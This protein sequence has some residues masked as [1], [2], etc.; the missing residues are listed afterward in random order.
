MPVQTVVRYLKPELRDA[1]T[2]PDIGDRESR[3]ANT[4]KRPV[5]IHDARPRLASGDIALDEHGFALEQHVSAVGDFHDK[6]EVERTYYPEMHALLRRLT[7]AS[8]VY[9]TQ[10][11]VRTEDT[12]NFN[13]AY[14]RFV[15]CD[16]SITN[17]REAA[18]NLLTQ[19]GEDPD[20]FSHFAWYNTWQPVE[21]EVFQNPLAVID[22][23]SLESGDVVDYYYT[24][25]G[26]TSISSMPVENDAH[27]FFYFSRMQT[28]EV[29]VIKQLDTRAELATCCP[30]TSFVD[31]DVPDDMPGRRSI[32][33]RLLC[34]FD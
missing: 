3:R 17:P 4:I 5:V 10:H 31:P 22:A 15:H 7:G 33:V 11:V 34:A 16:Y 8:A 27:R 25:Y 18:E 26:K 30:H 24:G 14:A 6:A 1:P 21:R 13:L 29:L 12:S 28:A 23:T 9:T 19:R 32:E 2:P 20:R